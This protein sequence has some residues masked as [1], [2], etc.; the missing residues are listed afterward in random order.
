M[1]NCG[2]IVVRVFCLVHLFDGVIFRR[3]ALGLDIRFQIFDIYTFEKYSEK[4]Q[5]NKL[6]TNQLW[7]VNPVFWCMLSLRNMLLTLQIIV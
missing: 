7:S 3:S 2:L 1:G 6:V 5:Q 4:F